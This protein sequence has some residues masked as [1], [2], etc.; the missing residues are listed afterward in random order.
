MS[1]LSFSDIVTSFTIWDFLSELS[2]SFSQMDIYKAGIIDSHGKFLKKP[3]DYKTDRERKA[4]SAY[5]RLIVVLKRALLTSSDPL[6]RYTTTNPMAALN[7]LAEEVESF[8]GDKQAF[9][10]YVMPLFEEGMSVG[11]GGIVGVSDTVGA[12]EDPTKQTNIVVSPRAAK[13]H[14][15]KVR[16]TAPHTGRTIL[17]SLLM[18]AKGRVVETT[19]H[20]TH[21]GDFLY[22][23]KPELAIKHLN[24]VHT[25]FMGRGTPNH[26]MSLKADG[27][28]SIVIKKHKDGTPAVAYKSGAAEFTDEDQI[29]AAG[30]EHF[31]RE[32]IPA[33][34]LA[35][36]LNLKPG[37]AVQGDL[38][39]T[40]GHQGTIQPNA[41][42]YHA[43]HGAEIGFAPHSQYST[44]GLNLHKTSSHPDH[45]GLQAAGAFIP[46]LAITPKTKLSLTGKRHKA[47]TSSIAAAQ[48]AL[49]QKGTTEFLRKL[50]QDKKFHRMLQEYSNHA[51][52][53]SGERTV[54][55][56]RNFIPVHMAKASQ[57]NLS[58]KTKKA[59]M[60]AFHKTIADNGHHLHNAFTAHTHI[61]TAKHAL[62]DQFGEHGDQFELKTTSGEHEGFVS[63][64]GRPGATET[65]AKFVREGPNGFPAKNTE[66]AIK[67]FGKAPEA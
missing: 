8:G 53:T 41:I 33:L 50:P 51:A 21:L 18:E 35:K 31:T 24:A 43:P 46:N 42:T 25:R 10:E 65:Q 22:Y 67:R 57:K 63:S 6:I 32:L 28:M 17:E 26:K 12:Q 62:L 7:A 27:G 39:F 15:R 19:G 58:E 47:V 48:K 40:S 14:K 38:L 49:A 64:M 61:N 1:N 37:T 56:L 60:D 4:G 54:E 5:N 30:K 23:G 20:M 9:L 45:S 29:R 16:R 66:N 3:E 52:R 13:N 34:K 59:M 44:D 2:R 36:G 55:G 11:G